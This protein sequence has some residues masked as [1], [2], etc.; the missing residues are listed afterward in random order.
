MLVPSPHVAE[1]H[2]TKNALSVVER[3]GAILLKDGDVVDQLGQAVTQLLQDAEA[4]A[5]MACAMKATARPD[6]AAAVAR[7]V[8]DLLDSR[9]P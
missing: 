4:N 7:E 9:R 3:G 8:L 6:A 2:Q 1:D 5:T